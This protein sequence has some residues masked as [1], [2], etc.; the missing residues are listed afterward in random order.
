MLAAADPAGCAFMC[1]TP[2]VVTLAVVVDIVVA[3][4]VVVDTAK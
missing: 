3:V 1:G 2:P 4:D